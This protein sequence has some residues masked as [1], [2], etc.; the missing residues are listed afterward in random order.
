MI[1]TRSVAPWVVLL[2]F[3]AACGGGGEAGGSSTAT[4][5]NSDAQ[6]TLDS[7]PSTPTDSASQPTT[8][9]PST[10]QPGETGVNKA[11]TTS[12]TRG[13]LRGL[14]YEPVFSDVRQ[15]LDHDF[16]MPV[17]LVGR[18]G[19]RYN[20]L[21]TREGRVWIVEDD[22]FLNPPVLDLRD[23]ILIGREGF[24]SLRTT[25]S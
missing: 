24:G 18:P 19:G 17:Q 7:S 11:E 8:S 4:P 12:T 5:E 20:Y 23:N 3:A 6:T 10:A 1:K 13:P 2:V 22:A 25:P 21:I 9:P 16:A 14:R 15:T